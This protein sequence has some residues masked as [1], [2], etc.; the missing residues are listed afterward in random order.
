MAKGDLIRAMDRAVIE[1]LR[2]TKKTRKVKDAESGIETDQPVLTTK[3]KAAAIQ[4]GTNYLRT[5]DQIIDETGASELDNL[6][7]ELNRTSERQRGRPKPPR[8]RPFQRRTHA[9]VEPVSDEG[10]M[11]TT[12][13]AAS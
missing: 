3:E 12:A 2:D 4:V 8:G 6:R 11:G 5:R 10:N 7:G 13:D 1:L 9:P